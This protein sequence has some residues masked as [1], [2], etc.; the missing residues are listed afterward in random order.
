MRTRIIRFALLA[1]FLTGV[2]ACPLAGEE[3]A[4]GIRGPVVGYVLDVT[5]QDDTIDAIQSLAV[6]MSNRMG[7]SNSSSVQMK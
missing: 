1:G 4:A 3:S 6:T 2:A 7:T 5:K